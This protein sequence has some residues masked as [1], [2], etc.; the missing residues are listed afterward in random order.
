MEL[1][2]ADWTGQYNDNHHHLQALLADADHHPGLLAPH[3]QAHVRAALVLLRLP[4]PPRP[5]VQV[6]G[7]R[8]GR[9]E[10]EGQ[11]GASGGGLWSGARVRVAEDG[12][13]R[14]EHALQGIHR[15]CGSHG[16]DET[17]SKTS[18]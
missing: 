7:Q 2:C 8:E 11:A 10:G 15:V 9:R 5:V 4:T 1:R 13:L 17:E 18:S 6:G 3:A 14:R 12:Q 16:M